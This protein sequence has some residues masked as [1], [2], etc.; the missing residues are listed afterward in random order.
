MASLR[1][2]TFRTYSSQ[3]ALFHLV[4]GSETDINIWAKWELPIRSVC[5]PSEAFRKIIDNTLKKEQD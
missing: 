1:S 2:S 4:G 5:S 3:A